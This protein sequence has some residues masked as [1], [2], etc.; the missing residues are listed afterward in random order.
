[1]K[2]NKTVNAFLTSKYFINFQSKKHLKKS[3]NYQS[4]YFVKENSMD[5]ISNAL[6]NHL[7]IPLS[8]FDETSYKYKSPSTGKI[9]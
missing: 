6:H 8:V 1:M 2:T 4:K 7:T 9:I 3:S 5:T